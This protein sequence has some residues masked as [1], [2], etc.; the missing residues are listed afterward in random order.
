MIKTI[1]LALLQKKYRDKYGIHIEIIRYGNYWDYM[2]DS[3][4]YRLGPNTSP[5]FL[6]Y[7]DALEKAIKHIKQLKID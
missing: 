1:R 2:L 7:E 6:S 4:F 3:S 5:L